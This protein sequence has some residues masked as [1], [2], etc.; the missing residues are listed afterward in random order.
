MQIV[1]RH[2]DVVGERAVVT[3]D[4]DRGAIGAMRRPAGQA[5]RAPP[6]VAVDL[7]DDTPPGE[8]TVFG[9]ADEL[10]AEHAAEA[11]IPVDELE[12]RVAH[13]GAYDADRDFPIVRRWNRPFR[14][15]GNRITVQHEGSHVPPR[16]SGS[17]EPH[18]YEETVTRDAGA[19]ARGGSLGR[20]SDERAGNRCE[21]MS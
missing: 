9:N 16:R 6:A 14:L 3:G 12:I 8:R 19:R 17:S 7:A 20:S 15:Q 11:H 5:R 18:R 2:G 10:V 4:A 21:A 13:A 1:L